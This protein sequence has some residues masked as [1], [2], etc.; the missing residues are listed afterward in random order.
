M[1]VV[2]GFVVWV[3]I[4]LDGGVCVD[5]FVVIVLFGLFVLLFGMDV[6]GWLY[7]S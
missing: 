6:L 7:F 5:Y 1:G 2:C 3:D 4:V